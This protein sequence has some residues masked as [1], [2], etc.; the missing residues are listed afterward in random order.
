MKHRHAFTLVE[1]LTVIAIIGLLVGLLL[2]AVQ[3][4]REAGRRS[5]C[6][7]NLRQIG[8]GLANHESVKKDYPP[9]CD[10][11]STSWVFQERKPAISSFVMLLPFLE[12]EEIYAQA[13]RGTG[14]TPV[15][16]L[17]RSTDLAPMWTR[18]IPTFICPSDMAASESYAKRLGPSSYAANKGD[19]W[20]PNTI[21]Q[22]APY[23]GSR[24]VFTGL[25]DDSRG[26]FGV[27]VKL[28]P[29]DLRDGLSTTLAYAERRIYRGE[30]DRVPDAMWGNGN[31]NSEPNACRIPA[32]LASKVV[33]NMFVGSRVPVAGWPNRDNYSSWSSGL[34]FYH[35][36]VTAVPPNGPS[37]D[38][39]GSPW[40]N[41]GLYTAS[42]YHP[43]GI[44]ITMGDGSVRWIAEGIDCGNQSSPA[45]HRTIGPG[46]QSPFGVWGA[47]GSRF[48]GETARV[49]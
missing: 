33:G 5:Q 12:Q 13:A 39:N 27:N 47:L 2:P 44:N 6:Q 42:S 4:A 24:S 23:A 31:S 43:G 26:M 14:S 36:I 25:K 3:G 37:C 40:W 49:D 21:G 32:V 8:Q 35:G 7:N 30:P 20:L 46:G 28:R 17:P 10:M 11:V 16:F 45:D 9:M 15:P 22:T 18:R 38:L 48:G 1:L 29:Q 34:A 19:S 41:V